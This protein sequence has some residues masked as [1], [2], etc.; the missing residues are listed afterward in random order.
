M[1]AAR[2]VVVVAGTPAPQGSKTRMGNGAM[3]E[4]SPAVRPWREA[5]RH[6]A[7][8]AA[9]ARGWAPP[10]AARVVAVFTLRRPAHHYGTGR[11]AHLLKG[12]APR[13]PTGRPDVDK[14]ARSTLDALTDAGVLGDDAHAVQLVAAKC[15]PGGDLDALDGPGAVIT[16]VDLT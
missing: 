11:N 12:S 6:E 1:S 16:V 2:L 15:Y 10:A 13:Y 9:R 3:V 5:V 7:D 14:L 8:L 4:S